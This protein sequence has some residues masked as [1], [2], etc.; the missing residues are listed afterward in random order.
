MATAIAAIALVTPMRA[1]DGKATFV[2][3]CSSC[4]GETAGGGLG[5]WLRHETNPEAGHAVGMVGASGAD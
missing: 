4:H 3:A 2:R 5:Y 1:Q